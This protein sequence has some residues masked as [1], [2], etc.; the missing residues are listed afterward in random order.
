MRQTKNTYPHIVLQ[1]HYYKATQEIPLPTLVSRR[2]KE[3][4]VA[5]TL[6]KEFLYCVPVY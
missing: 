2:A 4:Y 3:E 5:K 6:I 1:R